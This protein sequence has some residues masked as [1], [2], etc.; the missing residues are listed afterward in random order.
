M[1]A[2][3]WWASVSANANY[4]K[5]VVLLFTMN[6]WFA[7][8]LPFSRVP[9]SSVSFLLIVG[10]IRTHLPDALEERCLPLPFAAVSP[11][12]AVIN[13]LIKG[14]LITRFAACSTL[15]P[16][17]SDCNFCWNSLDQLIIDTKG[18]RALCGTNENSKCVCLSQCILAN[19]KWQRQG[20]WMSW[21]N[22]N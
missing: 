17:Q 18:W 15:Y 14:K 12:G 1:S 16:C 5:W 10:L 3:E 21:I 6:L 13:Q 20:K 7:C 19:G 4:P 8:L 22:L 9:F 11:R 2:V